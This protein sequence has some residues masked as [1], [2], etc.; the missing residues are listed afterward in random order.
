MGHVTKEASVSSDPIGITVTASS[1]VRTRIVSGATDVSVGATLAGIVEAI[2]GVTIVHCSS[3]SRKDLRGIVR[4]AVGI[5][6]A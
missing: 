1:L 4:V 2:L 6:K 3:S 5:T